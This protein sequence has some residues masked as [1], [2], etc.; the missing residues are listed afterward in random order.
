MGFQ[1]GTVMKIQMAFAAML[2]AVCGVANAQMNALPQAR[3]ILVYGE[4]HARAIP[5]RFKVEVRFRVVDQKADT[6][7]LKVEDMVR[8]TLRE[9]QQANVPSTDVVATS[10]EIQPNSE[11]DNELRKSVFKG[12]AVTR[13]LMA[14][15]H[16]Q[17]SLKKFLAGLET[18]E[19]LQVSGVTTS[20][21]Q[22]G[23]LKRQ[24]RMKAIESTKQKAQVIAK[25]YGASIVGLYSVSDTPPEFDY[26]I[27]EGEWPMASAYEWR[28][29]GGSTSLDTVTVV[30]SGAINPEDMEFQTGYET[31]ADKIYSVFLIGD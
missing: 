19:Q 31:F 5:D 11:Y 12:I 27:S 9:L 26:G 1:R 3:H 23:D 24:L 21:S 29:R 2:L 18:S 16:S 10:L 15:F 28:D 14:N 25:A 30:G 6:A 22:E 8:K 4:A 13:T 17:E 7:R 20:L